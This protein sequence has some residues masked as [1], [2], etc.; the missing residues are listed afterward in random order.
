MRHLLAAAGLLALATAGCGAGA[1]PAATAGAKPGAKATATPAQLPGGGRIVFANPRRRVVAFYG[2]PSD[3]ALGT[4]GIGTPERVARRLRRVAK[5]YVQPGR[6]VLPAMELLASVATAAP[7]DD[8]QYRR[9][10]TNAVIRRY[11]RAARSVGA[12]LILD[13][14]PGRA[15]FLP[16][17]KRLRRWLR[18]PDVSLALDPEW[19]V[20]PTELPGQVIGSSD[21]SDVVRVGRWL[22]DLTAANDL[23]QKLM[24][25]HQFT[26]GMIK[27]RELLRPY[28]HVGFV[29][30]VDGF[31][32]AAVKKAK[33]RAFA[34]L[35]P[36]AF[37]GFKLFYREDSGLMT[38]KQVLR[39]RP[40][41]DVIVYE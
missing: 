35:V 3:P 15:Q 9:R 20:G 7:G 5:R 36:F 30:N 28:K 18:Q 12:L 8:G 10:T 27:R 6:P 40:A 29:L 37:N 39:L 24:V 22:D 26:D 11:L 13:I 41:P 16:E 33:Y 25:V 31:G 38:P 19:H 2:H 21:A 4:L 23:P 32:S 34:K 14:Q 17:A 1:Q